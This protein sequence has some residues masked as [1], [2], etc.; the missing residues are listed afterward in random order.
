MRLISISFLVRGTHLILGV[1]L[2][3]ERLGWNW[4]RVLTLFQR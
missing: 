1:A 4:N 2:A 3:E